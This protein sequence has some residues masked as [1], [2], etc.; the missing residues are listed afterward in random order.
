MFSVTPTSI[1]AMVSVLTTEVCPSSGDPAVCMQEMPRFWAEIARIVFP[2]HWG[3]IC[4][5][6]EEC[7]TLVKDSMPHCPECVARVNAIT[8]SLSLDYVIR[9]YIELCQD[10]PSVCSNLYPDTVDQCKQAIAELLPIALPLLAS[11]PR[12]WVDN[13]CHGWGCKP[14]DFTT[15]SPA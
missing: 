12:D 7:S 10:S 3:H 6:L 8:N 14:W 13:F 5:D 15:I 4:D 11:Q 2:E 1:A 9:S